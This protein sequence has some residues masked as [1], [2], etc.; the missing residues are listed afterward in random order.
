VYWLVVFIAGAKECLY[1][2]CCYNRA[3]ILRNT[4]GLQ[5]W[6]TCVGRATCS[7]FNKSVH[8]LT[9]LTNFLAD[10]LC[11][12]AVVW[13]ASIALCFEKIFCLASFLIYT[14][15]AAKVLW[16][17]RRQ[18]IV[19]THEGKCM[20]MN[21]ILAILGLL[22]AVVAVFVALQWWALILVALGL[23]SGFMGPLSDMASRTAYTVAAVAMPMI[24]DTL[25]AIPVVGGYLNGIIDNIAVFLAGIVIA[26]FLLVIASQILGSESDSASAD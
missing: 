22:G 2:Q 18:S 7:A 6:F 24:A 9:A 20:S 13:F 16:R 17:Q 26:N 3:P 25:D 10:R 19:K 5:P 23:L 21:R 1:Q 14:F 11:L 4:L 8:Y 12:G 15:S